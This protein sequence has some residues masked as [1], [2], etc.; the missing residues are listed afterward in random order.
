MTTDPWADGAGDPRE[1]AARQR[2]GMAARA[3]PLFVLVAAVAGLPGIEDELTPR[4]ALALAID[5]AGLVI[6]VLCLWHGFRNEHERGRGYAAVA[7]F[8][9]IGV[10]LLLLGSFASMVPFGRVR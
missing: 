8:F 6:G 4:T 1:A 5:G 2:V 3:A 10:A 9:G 7:T